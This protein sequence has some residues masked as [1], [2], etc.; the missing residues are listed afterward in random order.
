MAKT[1]KTGGQPS[2]APAPQ[3]TETSLQ[4]NV[5]GFEVENDTM[6]GFEQINTAT[7]AIPFVRILQKLSP[8]LD[9]QKPEYIEGAEEGMYFNTITKELYGA[10]VPLIALKFERVYIEWRPN[11]GGFVGYHTPENAERLTVDHTFGNWKT[12]D[13]NILQET[14]AYMVLIA[15]HEKEGLCVLSLASSSLKTARE[16]NRLMT[17]HVMPDGKR[18]LPYYLVWELGTEYMKN[19]KGS[20]YRPSVKFV[21][22]I[23]EGQYGAAK[24]ER[25]ALPSRKI[26]YAQLEGKSENAD[27]EVRSY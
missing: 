24:Q 27:E 3:K 15:G 4:A 18:A 10:K 16:W 21:G 13:G 14:Y 6:E 11:R 5:L 25:L 2:A 7:M 20:W 1:F 19:D 26:D 22:Y 12:K 9:K 23:T 17:T 8:Q